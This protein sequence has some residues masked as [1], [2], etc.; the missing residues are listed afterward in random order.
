LAASFIGPYVFP[1]AG[2]LAVVAALGVGVAVPE[3]LLLALVG[4]IASDQ[5]AY[6]AGRVG[7]SGL[8]HRMLLPHRREQLERRVHRHAVTALIP[9]R[10]VPGARTWIAVLAGVARLDYRRFSLL[11]LAG[12]ALWA[13]VFTVVGVVFGA[14]A[15]VEGIIDGIRHWV[16]P[17]VVTITLLI[18]AR[19][20]YIRRKG[21][22]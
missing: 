7:G 6:G 8:A 2:E 19:V 12:C 18:A 14:T 22:P 16:W 10:M 17:I 20:L 21:Q 3:V 1:A 11:N 5:L 15:D 13:A 9:G 4:S